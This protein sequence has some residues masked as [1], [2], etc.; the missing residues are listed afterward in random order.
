MGVHIQFTSQESPLSLIYL[1]SFLE[2]VSSWAREEQREREKRE[3]LKQLPCSVWSLIRDSIYNPGI[4][5]WAETKSWTLN[6][7]SHP[8]APMFSFLKSFP[9]GQALKSFPIFLLAA[10]AH[11][12]FFKL[13]WDFEEPL[14]GRPEGR[15]Y[16]HQLYMLRLWTGA[17][18][19]RLL[20]YWLL[21]H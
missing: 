19:Q 10:F 21:Q 12:C 14:F 18:L 4:L 9:Q 16:V 17:L 8:G 5:T 20:L 1:F 7:P 6:G 2:R 13:P 3:N 11:H 15:H